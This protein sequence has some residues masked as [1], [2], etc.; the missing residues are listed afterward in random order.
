MNNLSGGAR[1]YSRTALSC[2][3][4]RQR[5]P[6]SRWP[7]V[8]VVVLLWQL[9][10]GAAAEALHL[11]QAEMQDVAADRYTPAAASVHSATL[12]RGWRAVTLPHAYP[13]DPLGRG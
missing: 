1:S 5:A 9:A 2:L 11:T 3:P 6:L 13:S 8:W 7:A 4:G 10:A 12:P